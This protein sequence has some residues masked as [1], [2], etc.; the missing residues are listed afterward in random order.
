MYWTDYSASKIQRANLDGSGVEDLVTSGLSNPF[1][2]ALDVAGGKMY[3]TD[4]GT[5]KIQR[6]KCEDRCQKEYPDSEAMC[7]NEDKCKGCAECVASPP[8]DDA[9][10]SQLLSSSQLLG[11]LLVFCTDP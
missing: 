11:L 5:D 3:W 8:P 4:E 2:I 10:S 6:T 1:G 7:R 9:C